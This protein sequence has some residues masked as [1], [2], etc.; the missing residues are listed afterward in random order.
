M[1]KFIQNAQDSSYS[2][3]QWSKLGLVALVDSH[4]HVIFPKVLNFR[5][6]N[7]GLNRYPSIAR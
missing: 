4:A 3:D 1:N 5:E 7:N 2:I 6:V